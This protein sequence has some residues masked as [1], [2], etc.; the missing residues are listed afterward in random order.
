MIILV[1]LIKT[2]TTNF[3]T[4]GAFDLCICTHTHVCIVALKGMVRLCSEEK[5]PYFVILSG[6]G[7]LIYMS[8]NSVVLDHLL[9][10]LKYVLVIKC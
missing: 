4:V 6:Y 8:P 3:Q 10:V 9:S 1:K 2:A 5:S 7:C